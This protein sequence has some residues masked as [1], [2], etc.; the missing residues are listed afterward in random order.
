M[1]LTYLS[2]NGVSKYCHVAA[3]VLFPETISILAD[4]VR[5]KYI[6]VLSLI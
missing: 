6:I 4:Q 5:Y 1:K 3:F 2:A